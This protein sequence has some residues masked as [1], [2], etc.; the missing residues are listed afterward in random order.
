MTDINTVDQITSELD[1]F[2]PILQQT[3]LLNQ[4]DREFAQ[5]ASLQQGAPIEFM[6]TNVDQLYLDLNESMLLVR[7]K[8]TNADNSDIKA[9]TAGPVNYTLYSLFAK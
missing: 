6:V 9:D 5:L 3:V 7:V 1:L 8:I 2:G 4:F